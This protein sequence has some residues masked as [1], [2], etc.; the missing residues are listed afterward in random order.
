MDERTILEFKR[1]M[2]EDKMSDKFIKLGSYEAERLASSIADSVSIVAKEL[3]LK[4]P[5]DAKTF[6]KFIVGEYEKYRKENNL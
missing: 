3:D 4:A 5:I 6:V 1:S 2:G